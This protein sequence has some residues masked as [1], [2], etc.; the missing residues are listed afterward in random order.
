MMQFKKELKI[1]D[2][3]LD[4][5]NMKLLHLKIKHENKVYIGYLELDFNLS[6]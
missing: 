1:M 3:W 5:F 6:D 4:K 2:A